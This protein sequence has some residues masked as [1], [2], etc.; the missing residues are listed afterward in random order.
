MVKGQLFKYGNA[1][2]Y[3]IYVRQSAS[4]WIDR[5][6]S[7]IDLQY[8]LKSHAGLRSSNI[9]KNEMM[10]MKNAS[11]KQ[12]FFISLLWLERVPY[13][14][15]VTGQPGLLVLPACLRASGS[16]RRRDPWSG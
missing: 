7:Y 2:V 3:P 14:G 12:Y 1:Y 5:L 9:L 16:R 10:R 4:K 8:I 6:Y 13:S 11:G 15:E